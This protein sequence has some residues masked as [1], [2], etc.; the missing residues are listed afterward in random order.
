MMTIYVVKLL[1][2]T[3]I[4]AVVCSVRDRLH[5]QTWQKRWRDTGGCCLFGIGYYCFTGN[6]NALFTTV[7]LLIAT[8]I[9]EAQNAW[10]AN[11][12]R[13]RTARMIQRLSSITEQDP[14]E[15]LAEGEFVCD[16]CKYRSDHHA[17]FPCAVHPGEARTSCFDWEPL[18]FK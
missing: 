12:R 14:S 18:E 1:L 16:C 7:A 8:A 5:R 6:Q 2:A 11:R 4:L 9:I 10:L 3:C 17:L 15:I 13:L